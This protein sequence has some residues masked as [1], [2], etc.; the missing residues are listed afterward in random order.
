MKQTGKLAEAL[1]Q[2]SSTGI[3]IAEERTMNDMAFAAQKG[4]RNWVKKNFTLRNRWTVGGIQ[5]RKANKA[6]RKSEM[7]S[8]AGPLRVRAHYMKAQT[9]GEHMKGR[10]KFGKPVP[11]LFAR[12]GGSKKKVIK[13]KFLLSNL[14][15]VQRLHPNRIRGNR[16]TKMAAAGAKLARRNVNFGFVR[17][18]R[19]GEI[20]QIINRKGKVRNRRG[21]K[22]R[23]IY[24]IYERG[25]V[26][27]K[28]PWL[29][30]GINSAVRQ[31]PYFA[32]KALKFQVDRLAKKL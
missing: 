17:T 7:G 14:G 23:K 32:K 9:L 28:T 8:I 24:N 1:T 21:P 20:Y 25:L 4:S 5:V 6:R 18:P 31:G 16:R 22:M 19:G 29:Q 12:V 27:K 2:L 30:A 3:R 11:T 15:N 13:R 10:G 26:I